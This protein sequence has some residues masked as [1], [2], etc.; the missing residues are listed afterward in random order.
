[1]SQ[2]TKYTVIDAGVVVVRGVSRE[3][4]A[5]VIMARPHSRNKADGQPTSRLVRLVC[6]DGTFA[7]QTAESVRC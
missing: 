1:M 5:R 7:G 3:E 2:A 4:A 6:D